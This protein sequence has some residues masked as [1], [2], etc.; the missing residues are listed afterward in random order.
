MPSPT[1]P[2]MGC[3]EERGFEIGE[4]AGNRL[5]EARDRYADIRHHALLARRIGERRVIGIVPRFPET[6]AVLRLRGPCRAARTM[7]RRDGSKALCLLGDGS[8]GAVKLDEQG[9][10]FGE[11]QFRIGVAGADG[12]GIE[13]FDAR[14]GGTRLDRLDDGID[15]AFF[16]ALEGDDA[17]ADGFRN[18][19]EPKRHFRDDAERAFR[20]RDELVQ[21]R[22]RGRRGRSFRRPEAIGHDGGERRNVFAHGAVADCIGAGAARCDHAAE[23]RVG[24]GVDGEE[25][26]GVAEM[27]VERLA[28]HARLD[29]TTSRSS[30]FTST[31]RSMRVRSS[32]SPP[33]TAETWPSSEVPAPKGMT[34]SP[35]AARSDDGG[36]FLRRLRE[37]DG[38]GHRDRMPGLVAA[39]RLADR[40][41]HGEAVAEQRAE[42]GQRRLPALFPRR[43]AH[44][45]PPS[46]EERLSRREGHVRDRTSPWKWLASLNPSLTTFCVIPAKAGIHVPRPS[47]H[48]CRSAHGP[49]LSPG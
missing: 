42:F 45:V 2:T 27:L 16:D 22:P 36:D 31:M 44:G 12:Q 10:H 43:F 14:D 4:R 33:C 7:L 11:R 29:A 5:G 6:R 35:C 23:C 49:R 46:C 13:N 40:L 47:P 25:E 3:L 38:I 39:M 18:A 37:G 19:V 1:W 24:A 9:R 41:G 20:A 32:E 26:T 34:G 28:R 15:R 48:N 21:I 8:L 30:A 17:G